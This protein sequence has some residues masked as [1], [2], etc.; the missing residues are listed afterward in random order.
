MITKTEAALLYGYGYRLVDASGA[1]IIKI[2]SVHNNCFTSQTGIHVK[3]INF[4]RIGV[5]WFILVHPLSRLTTEIE[6]IGGPIDVLNKR[7]LNGNTYQA[8]EVEGETYLLANY[9][10]E[11]NVLY[12]WEAEQLMVWHFDCCNFLERGIGKEITV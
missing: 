8:T 11:V 9:R 12:N 5:D 6:G 1:N 10:P 3:P 4:D 2:D 7:A